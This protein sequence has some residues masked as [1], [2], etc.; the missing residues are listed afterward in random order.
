MKI[1]IRRLTPERENALQARRERGRGA[2]S[3]KG[4]LHWQCLTT[5]PSSSSRSPLTSPGE[6]LLVSSPGGKRLSSLTRRGKRRRRGERKEVLL[7]LIC[8]TICR[9]GERRNGSKEGNSG[10]SSRRVGERGEEG[11]G[12]YCS[13]LLHAGREGRGTLHETCNTRIRN[14]S[15]L[16]LYLSTQHRPFACPEK[17]TSEYLI[18]LKEIRKWKNIQPR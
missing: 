12:G 13:W 10:G 9:K 8:Q 18:S 7:R 4:A 14:S 15:Q 16:T 11:G 2:K 3:P 1:E 6:P 5:S 17:L